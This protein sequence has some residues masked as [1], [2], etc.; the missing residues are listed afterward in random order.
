MAGGRRGFREIRRTEL[1]EA[2]Q[3]A[4][5]GLCRDVW[6]TVFLYCRVIRA[7]MLTNETPWEDGDLYRQLSAT[8]DKLLSPLFCSFLLRML[9]LMTASLCDLSFSYRILKF[10]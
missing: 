1:G 7:E 10:K 4:G 8:T 6:E 3:E 9:V 2:L 5:N